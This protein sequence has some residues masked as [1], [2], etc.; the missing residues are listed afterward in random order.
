MEVLLQ[1]PLLHTRCCLNLEFEEGRIEPGPKILRL[2]YNID[3]QSL[4]NADA[5]MGFAINKKTRGAESKN[6]EP[7]VSYKN[8]LKSNRTESLYTF[9][10][11]GEGGSL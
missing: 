10:Y 9:R 5:I 3:R 8:Y 1:R 2:R 11:G 6:S 7:C 4:L